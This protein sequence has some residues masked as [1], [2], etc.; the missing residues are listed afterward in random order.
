M[1]ADANNSSSTLLDPGATFEGSPTSLA[2]HKWITIV[3][4]TDVPGELYIEWST[5]NDKW[6]LTD[7]EPVTRNFSAT[8]HVKALYYRVRF[9]NGGQKQSLFYLQSILYNEGGGDGA[10]ANVAVTSS[11]LPV[12]AATESTLSTLNGKITA[13]DTDNIGGNIDISSIPLPPG[14]ATETTLSAAEVHLGAI[15]TAVTGT[16]TVDGSGVTQPVS[17]ASLPLPTGA[18]TEATL[19]ALNAKI[20]MCDTDSMGGDINVTSSAL[21]TGAAT[22]TTL[23]AAEAHLGNIEGR[24]PSSLGSATTANSLSVTLSSDHANLPVTQGTTNVSVYNSIAVEET[25]LATGLG[26]VNII[27]VHIARASSN[28]VSIGFYNMSGTPGSG[29][30]PVM[31]LCLDNDSNIT[32]MLPAG[33]QVPFTTGLGL[34]AVSSFDP[35]SSTNATPTDIGITIFYTT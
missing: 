11:A 35:T 30:T 7:K 28:R 25:G 2:G 32:V 10:A 34:R 4:A 13:C 23:S 16:L 1:S 29:D 12:G 19:A 17:A 18:S 3:A 14:A 20:V 31:N 9:K 5:D 24:L 15:D 22:E 27:G 26:A 33:Y 21:P 6:I 8:I